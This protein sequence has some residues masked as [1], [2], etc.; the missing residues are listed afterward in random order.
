MRKHPLLLKESVIFIIFLLLGTTL[1]QAV[2]TNISKPSLIRSNTTSG[3][4]TEQSDVTCRYFTIRGVEEIQKE[5]SR[6]DSDKLSAL[7]DGSEVEVIVSEL[8]RLGLVP[9]SMSSEQ[10]D[11][12]ISGEYCKKAFARCSDK[13]TSVNLGKEVQQNFLC[14]MKGEAGSYLSRNLRAQLLAIL[15]V[16]PTLALFILDILLQAI[17]PKYPLI[18]KF[19]VIPGMYWGFGIVGTFA[20]ILFFIIEAILTILDNMPVKLSVFQV[21]SLEESYNGPYV[22]INTSGAAGNWSLYGYRIRLDLLGFFGVWLSVVNPDTRY[23]RFIGSSLY[24]KAECS[25]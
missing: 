2:V 16:Y 8:T 1:G 9:S 15:T 10:V 4:R 17:F 3:P 6:Q 24:V 18:F 19:P 11:N 5:I 13:L 22:H 7:M 25:T 12:L 21:I 23:S 20:W 14:T